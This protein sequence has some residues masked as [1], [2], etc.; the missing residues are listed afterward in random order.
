MKYYY[1]YDYKI[2]DIRLIKKLETCRY[3]AIKETKEDFYGNEHVTYQFNGYS[4]PLLCN[5]YDNFAII[6]SP[7]EYAGSYTYSGEDVIT[8]HSTYSRFDTYRKIY[9]FGVPF[10]VKSL[11]CDEDVVLA[12]ETDCGF[13]KQLIKAL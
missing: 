4:R 10:M 8:L 6:H 13:I 12:A 7:Y 5:V 1:I 2:T 11:L 9:I 3:F